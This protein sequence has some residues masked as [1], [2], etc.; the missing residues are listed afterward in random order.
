MDLFERM[1]F[2]TC[3]SSVC[4]LAHLRERLPVFSLATLSLALFL[5]PV[6]ESAGQA[7]WQ[8]TVEVIVPVEEGSVMRALV[9]SVALMPKAQGLPLRR[10]PQ[11]DTA[12]SL[13]KIRTALESEGLALTSATHVFITYRFGQ[14]S[15][16]LQRSVLG[17]HYIYRSSAGN[18]ED[19]S[20]LYVDLSEENQRQR[21]LREKGTPVAAN[22][23][24]FRSFREQLSFSQLRSEATVVR[25]GNEIIRD[26]GEAAAAKQKIFSTIRNL[27]YE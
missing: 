23:V 9:D 4:D 26:A 3:V 6:R 18:E 20:I 21:L 22:E 13:D 7:R 5:L 10:A 17:L 27:I 16:Q 12:T 15:G 24:A 2:R 19:V 1:R 25:V 14:D 11:S 8:Q